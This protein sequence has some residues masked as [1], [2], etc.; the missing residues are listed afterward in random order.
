MSKLTHIL[1]IAAV[2][3]TGIAG[4]AFAH[5]HLKSATPAENAVVTTS[6]TELDLT[7]SEGLNLKFSSAT[8]TGA[9]KA[10]VATDKAK[11][12]TG[13]D[14]TLVIPI[15]KPLSAGG[16]TVNWQVLSTDG[17][18]TKGSYTFTVKP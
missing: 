1:T 3:S 6:P 8:V 11:L 17:H 4:E 7:F 18:K 15:S 12:A 9:D 13:D 10:A 5:A 16:Y 14:K 2:L